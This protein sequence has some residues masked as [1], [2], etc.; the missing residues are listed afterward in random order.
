MTATDLKFDKR[1][2]DN[3]KTLHPSVRP[4]AHEFM[5]NASLYLREKHPNVQVKIISGTRSY[6]EQDELYR[7]GRSKPGRIVTNAPGGHSNHNFGIAFDIGLFRG[8]HYLEESPIY[9][10]LGPVG[11]SVGFEWGGRWKRFSDEP[12]YQFRPKWAERM[13]ER[14]MLAMFRRKVANEE[15]ILA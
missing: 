9:R 8:G 10:E 15:D 7:Q 4:K 11:E 5:Y 1:S 12:H 13:K 2:E 3:M 14:E 6:E